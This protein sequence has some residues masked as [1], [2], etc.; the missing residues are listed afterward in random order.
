[1][2]PYQKLTCVCEKNVN[3]FLYHLH[4]LQKNLLGLGVLFS[5]YGAD[6]GIQMV[7]GVTHL[8]LVQSTTGGAHSVHDT[9]SLSCQADKY[10]HT[11]SRPIN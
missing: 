7:N 3:P 5:G 6:T 1:M 4:S 10:D 9:V 8:F 11:N 2:T